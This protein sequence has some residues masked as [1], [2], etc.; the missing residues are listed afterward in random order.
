MLWNSHSSNTKQ[1]NAN[2]REQI[3]RLHISS[4]VVP[5]LSKNLQRHTLGLVMDLNCLTWILKSKIHIVVLN[6]LGRLVS[7]VAFADFTTLS[8]QLIE[9]RHFSQ[10]CPLGEAH[11]TF[12]APTIGT[13]IL[14]QGPK[15]MV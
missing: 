4:N 3:I 8:S 10:L 2:E 14:V 12:S 11:A 9:H 5:N 7:L 13:I 15:V 1:P 6:D